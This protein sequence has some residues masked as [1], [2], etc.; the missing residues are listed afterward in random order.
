MKTPVSSTCMFPLADKKREKYFKRLVMG[1][2]YENFPMHA[3]NFF[4]TRKVCYLASL[5]IVETKALTK[6]S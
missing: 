6:S 5:L 1:Q 2:L 4:N 3:M